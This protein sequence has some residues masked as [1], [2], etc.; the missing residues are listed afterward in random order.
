V[1][2]T[3]LPA[4]ATAGIV[5]GEKGE[6]LAAAATR[7]LGFSQHRLK[8]AVRALSGGNQQKLV[9]GKWLHRKPRFLLLDEPTRGIDIGAKAE[10][11]AAIR[12][13]ANEG[14]SVILVSSEL[15]EVVQQA[16]RIAV[17]ANRGILATLDH[18]NAT[19]ERILG[20]IFSVEGHG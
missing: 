9:V 1:I 14:L 5:R 16:D 3:D 2:L 20:L 15:G 4:A 12:R 10:L 19:V 18:S 13:L 17:L 7:P 8:D 11:Y 6:E